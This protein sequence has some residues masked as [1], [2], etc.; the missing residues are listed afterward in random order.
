M[1][2]PR[3][4]RCWRV[5]LV[6]LAAVVAV[7]ALMPAPP[8]Q[9]DLG[10]DNLNHAGA[11]AAMAVCA[12]FGWRDA[13]TALAGVLLALLAFGAAIELLQLLVPTRSAEWGDLLADGAGIAAGA[14]LARLALARRRRGGDAQ[15]AH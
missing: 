5:L 11:F 13:R 4:E 3:R 14:L 15:S 1:K 9:A 10:W 12:V 2:L 6:V 7:L 8:P